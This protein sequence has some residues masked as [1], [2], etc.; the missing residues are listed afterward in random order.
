MDITYYIYEYISG[1]LKGC[2]FSK[3][4]DKD[5][6]KTVYGDIV[7]KFILKTTNKRERDRCLKISGET[8]SYNDIKDYYKNQYYTKT[9][10][11]K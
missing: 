7:A 4:D 11:R 3:E 2:R 8:L 6:T 1:P 5:Y 9:D 10:G